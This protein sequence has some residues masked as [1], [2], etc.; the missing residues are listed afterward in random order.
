M[1]LGARGERVHVVMGDGTPDQMTPRGG[2]HGKGDPGGMGG[3][4]LGPGITTLWEPEGT[5]E[6]RGA[7]GDWGCGQPVGQRTG[8]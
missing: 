6:K 4:G 5:L 7:L 2:A 3:G 1:R 8:S